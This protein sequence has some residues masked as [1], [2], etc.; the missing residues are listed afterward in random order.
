MGNSCSAVSDDDCNEITAS[1][2]HDTKSIIPVSAPGAN[3]HDGTTSTSPLPGSS[4]ALVV[5]R[6]GSTHPESASTLGPS[7]R[8]FLVSEWEVARGS[9]KQPKQEPVTSYDDT[10][11]T[12]LTLDYPSGLTRTFMI[13]KS[14]KD[15]GY[16]TI[17]T[18]EGHLV[19][20]LSNK[21]L[22]TQRR[23]LPVQPNP[24]FML[25][26]DILRA[27]VSV[28]NQQNGTI[29]TDHIEEEQH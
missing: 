10:Y 3:F 28:R 21:H 12:H 16:A 20:L 1:G 11:P 18:P 8:R 14:G 2:M 4:A 19:T 17:S 27:P 15:L 13:S 7:A 29:F 6:D 26:D 5:E 24:Q 9:S 23:T 25:D 22:R